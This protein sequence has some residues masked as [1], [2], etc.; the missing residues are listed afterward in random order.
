MI[1]MTG[2]RSSSAAATRVGRRPRRLGAGA[3][4]TSRSPAGTRLAGAADGTAQLP[5]AVLD[6][7]LRDVGQGLPDDVLAHLGHPDL[8]LDEGDRHLDHAQPGPHGSQGQVDLEAVALRLDAG[9]PH[10]AQRTRAVGAVA[11]GRVVDVHAEHDLGVDVGAD[12]EDLA[13]HRPVAHLAA[14]DPAGS[15]G[16]VGVGEGGEDGGQLLGLVRAVGVHLD[17]GVVALVE[18]D[19]ETG[20]VGLAE[21][22]LARAVHDPHLRVAR[23]QA[24]GEVARAVGRVVVEDDDVGRGDAGTHARHDPGQVLPLVV[25]RD[26]HGH[27]GHRLTLRHGHALPC[28]LCCRHCCRRSCRLC[29]RRCRHPGGPHA[30]PNRRSWPAGRRSSTSPA[31][32]AHSGD[33]PSRVAT[34]VASRNGRAP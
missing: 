29:G 23:G 13:A 16:E 31:A 15:D 26:E 7:P 3:A 25:G 19:R 6:A 20:E 34:V 32:A 2:R 12:R 33:S 4:V 17:R 5:H 14:L 9:Q 27:L 1:S 11:G 18:G 10:R 24:V 30:G 22:L 21:A 8:A 28:H